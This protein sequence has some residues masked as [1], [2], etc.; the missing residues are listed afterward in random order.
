MR[1]FHGQISAVGARF[2]AR[3][4]RRATS[5]GHFMRRE[6]PDHPVGAAHAPVTTDP[7]HLDLDRGVHQ[8]RVSESGLSGMT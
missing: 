5:G 7:V 8:G 2:S 1:P 3:S 4:G 6:T